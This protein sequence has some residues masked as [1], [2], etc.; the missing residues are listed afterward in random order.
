MITRDSPEY[1]KFKE[2]A[3]LAESNFSLAQLFI[4]ASCKSFYRLTARL[5]PL[6]EFYPP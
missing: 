1:A 5:N 2:R 4:D 6:I 3:G